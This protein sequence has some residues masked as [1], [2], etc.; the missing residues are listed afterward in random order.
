MLQELEQKLIDKN[1]SHL[2][3]YNIF[4]TRWEERDIQKIIENDR[5]Q[6]D[7]YLNIIQKAK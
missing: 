3:D 4:V 2:V 5:E 7:L 6:R 1:M